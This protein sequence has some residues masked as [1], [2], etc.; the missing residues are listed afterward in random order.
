MLQRSIG[1]LFAVFLVA[2]FLLSTTAVQASD[3]LNKKGN[4][5]D[6][7]SKPVVN[8]QPDHEDFVWHNGL[9]ERIFGDRAI[10]L[11]DDVIT[12]K[13]PSR[14]EDPAVVPLKIK[15]AFAQSEQRYIKTV[16]VVIDQN[17]VPLAG[18]FHFTGKSGR[19]DL[20]LRVRVNAFTPVRAVAETNDGQL[21]MS[22]SFVKASGGCSAPVPADLSRALTGAGKM[23]M[24]TLGLALNE[25]TRAQLKIKHPNISGM[26]L[27]FAT[28]QYLPAH[29]VEK[30][31]VSFNGE[32][33]MTAE[34]DLAISTDPSFGFYFVPDR[35]GEL[36]VEIIDT[37]K[38]AFR[39]T[40]KV[41]P[42]A[43]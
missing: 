41:K 26:Q 5:K 8:V 38:Q 29:F 15:A 35:Q 16:Y 28:N 14:A 7:E 4:K 25:P 32:P 10:T 17:P 18:T 33:I 6:E 22:K 13:A 24:R 9:R 42:G 1:M 2:V 31:N 37:Q 43:Y 40:L 19:A 20:A 34:T 27:D 21:Y 3:S 36:E 12:L 39:K 11:S 23:H 30:I